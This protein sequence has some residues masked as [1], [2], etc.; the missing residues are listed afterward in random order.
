MRLLLILLGAAAAQAGFVEEVIE[1]VEKDRVEEYF[2]TVVIPAREA[3]LEEQ[4]S[5]GERNASALTCASEDFRVLEADRK[6]VIVGGGPAGLT[7]AVY[8]ARADLEPLV[9]ARDGGQLEATS[10]VDNFPG[11]DEGVDAVDLVNR[12]ERQA[13]RFGATI[14]ACDITGVDLRCRPFRVYCENEEEITSS[15]LVV[16]AGASPRWLGVPG[17]HKFLSKGVHTCATCDGYFYRNGHAAVIGGG[18]TAME[19]ALFLARICERVTLVHRGDTFRASK[20]MA[21]R[22]LKHPNI[23]ILW[24]TVVEAFKGDDDDDD[25]KLSALELR[26]DQSR[27]VLRVDAAFVAIGHTPNTGLFDVRKNLEGYIYTAPGSTLT[28]VPG[29][30]AAGDVQD[31]VYRQAITS[32]GT[33]A[34]AAIDAE[35]WLCEH[36]C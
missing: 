33:G 20:T 34:M 32:A 23:L 27:T 36:G 2:E 4:I 30:F 16:A 6:V 14:K 22:V 35:R 7:A 29:V 15:A 10:R 24:N 28:S 9:I 31:P 8:A 25:Q 19:Q 18:D 5:V 1:A 21:T 26:N 12:I 3:S 17:E 13:K 11:F